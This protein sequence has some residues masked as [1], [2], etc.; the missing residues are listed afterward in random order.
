MV[1]L[2]RSGKSTRAM[3]LSIALHAPVVERDSIRLALY[4][5]PYRPEGEGMVKAL[6]DLFIKTLFHTGYTTVI[7]DETNFSKAAR[8]R[9]IHPDWETSFVVVDT[10]ADVCK[11]RAIITGQ[12]YLL[13]VIDEMHA[14]YEPLGPEER[15]FDYQ[16]VVV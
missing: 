5:L 9:R 1:G 8:Q 16:A 6:D 15:L 2:P 11:E 13:S 4:G 10:P 3:Q 7:V 14:R 12:E